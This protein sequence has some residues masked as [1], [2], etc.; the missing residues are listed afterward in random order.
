VL[1]N[2][3]KGGAAMNDSEI[4]SVAE[5]LAASLDVIVEDKQAI[6][7]NMRKTNCPTI[8]ILSNGNYTL[9]IDKYYIAYSKDGKPDVR[10]VF[11]SQHHVSEELTEICNMLKD[12]EPSD[13]IT[14][15]GIREQMREALKS[16]AASGEDFYLAESEDAGDHRH[17]ELSDEPWLM[18]LCPKCASQFYDT[19][20]QYIRRTDKSFKETC[21][22][23][24]SRQGFEYEIVRV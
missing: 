17:I 15:S 16:M 2:K 4:L 18:T 14:L 11:V 24:D 9:W 12:C 19:P 10:Y 8:T 6:L 7:K 22:Y 13:Y 5:K 20:S 3:E 21:D 23:C 1:L